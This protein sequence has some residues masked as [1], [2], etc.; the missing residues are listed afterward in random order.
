MDVNLRC[1]SVGLSVYVRMWSCR[2][3]MHALHADIKPAHL[4]FKDHAEVK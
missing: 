4:K 3:P 1:M 2:G